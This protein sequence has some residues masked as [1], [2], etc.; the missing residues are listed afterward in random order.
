MVQAVGGCLARPPAG[1][2]ALVE[3]GPYGV[4]ATGRARPPKVGV[5]RPHRQ[6]AAPRPLDQ[7]VAGRGRGPAVVGLPAQT[8]GEGE[9][10]VRRPG[11]VAVRPPVAR[12]GAPPGPRVARPASGLPAVGVDAVVRDV[13]DAADSGPT[14]P[15]EVPCLGLRV[16]RPAYGRPRHPS[17]WATARPAGRPARPFAGGGEDGRAGPR[18]YALP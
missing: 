5:D 15:S 16:R 1:R 2:P 18:P 12:G 11:K 7:R 13:G 3:V 14:S 9:G 10:R 4:A 8:V 17:A 6:E